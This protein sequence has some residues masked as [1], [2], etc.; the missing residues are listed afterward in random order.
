MTYDQWKT[1]DP[2]EYLPN[3]EEQEPMPQTFFQDFKTDNDDPVTVEYGYEADGC[4]CIVQAWRE[5]QELGDVAI[6]VKLTDNEEQRM[7][8]WIAEHR[9]WSD[10][11]DS[12]DDYVR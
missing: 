2:R 4:V 9:Y 7:C 5:P 3:D 1:T 8:T 12:G 10:H 11:E 6:D